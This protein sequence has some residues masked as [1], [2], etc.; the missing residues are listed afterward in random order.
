MTDRALFKSFSTC[1][2]S[3]VDISD[4]EGA[5]IILDLCS[6]V[7]EEFHNRFDFIIDAGSLDNIF[8]PDPRST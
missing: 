7:P 4:Y 8:D 5:E 1:S 2:V 6:D 3:A